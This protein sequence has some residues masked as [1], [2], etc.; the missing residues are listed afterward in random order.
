MLWNTRSRAKILIVDDEASV[1]ELVGEILSLEFQVLFAPTAADAIRIAEKEKPDLVV[2]DIIMPQMD[3]F[4]VCKKLRSK[5][6]TQN[7]P[8]IFLSAIDDPEK[9]VRA[10]ALG[11]ED[12]VTKPFQPQE[13]LARVM[14]RLNH[15]LITSANPF[16]KGHLISCGNLILN[17][18]NRTIKIDEKVIPVLE[19]ESILLEH[20]MAHIDEICSRESLAKLV[21]H[22]Q[23]EINVRNLDPHISSLRKKT[24]GF[25][26]TLETAY[27]LGYILKKN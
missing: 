19:T 4:E 26:H 16:G 27:G 6:E 15:K 11:A 18:S 13:L 17:K 14:A 7:L 25:D 24:K 21:W 12:Y 3:G 20:L 9:K 10:F 2:L 23:S 5:S 8:I 22:D 1:R